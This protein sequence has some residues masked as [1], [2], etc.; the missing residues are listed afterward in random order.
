MKIVIYKSMANKFTKLVATFCF[1]QYNKLRNQY[2][3][4][5]EAKS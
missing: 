4:V 3:C 5:E 2:E 1:V